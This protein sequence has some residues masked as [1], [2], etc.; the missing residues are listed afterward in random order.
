MTVERIEGP[1]PGGPWGYVV[2]KNGFAL[3]VV[4]TREC[5][6]GWDEPGLRMRDA[7]LHRLV[8]R[9]EDCAGD[10]T[11]VHPCCELVGGACASSGMLLT[12]ERVFSELAV[13]DGTGWE[14][15][16]AFWQ[17][18]EVLLDGLRSE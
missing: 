9:M 17:G 6:S 3:E 18:L 5:L 15:P 7:L 14:Q 12:V 13:K 1:R 11:Y 2:R 4:V 10:E 16:E 8:A